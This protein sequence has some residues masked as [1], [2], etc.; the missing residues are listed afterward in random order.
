MSVFNN[1]SVV[2]FDAEKKSPA[3]NNFNSIKGID[4]NKT[5]TPS[6]KPF[7]LILRKV[8]EFKKN[9]LFSRYNKRINY[10]F[11]LEFNR[12]TH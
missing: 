1:F 9:N 10:L 7:T 4:Q 3:T 11:T 6:L 8:R 5:M 2:V 12:I